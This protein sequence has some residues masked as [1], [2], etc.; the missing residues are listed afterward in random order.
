MLHS[1]ASKTAPVGNGQ[2]I[3]QCQQVVR[4]TFGF[5]CHLGAALFQRLEVGGFLEGGS[6]RS[7]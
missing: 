7:R 2:A 4:E 6:R 1:F 3:A 5:P